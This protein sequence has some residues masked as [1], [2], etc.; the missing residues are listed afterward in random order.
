VFLGSTCGDRRLGADVAPPQ[1]ARRG[2]DLLGALRRCCFGVETRSPFAS[3]N[4]RPIA[5]HLSPRP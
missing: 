1:L 5:T 2:A 3:A 4:D